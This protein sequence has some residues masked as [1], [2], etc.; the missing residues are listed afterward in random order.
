[1]FEEKL[2]N[3]LIMRNVRT[4][5]D[6]LKYV[7]LNRKYIN[8]FE[9]STCNILLRN[10]KTMTKEDF[11]LI[12]D[13]FSGD[14]L[15]TIC[16][17]P[18]EACFEGIVIQVAMLEMVLSHP[19]HRKLGLI[20]RLIQHFLSEVDKRG[21][22]ISVITGI[23]F[24]YRQYGYSYA[25]DLGTNE[26]LPACKL[27]AFSGS[28]SASYRLRKADQNDITQLASCYMA[29][30]QNKQVFIMRSC[31]HWSY[32]INEAKFD[33]RVVEDILT[34]SVTGYFLLKEADDKKTMTIFE[35]ELPNRAAMKEALSLLLSASTKEL[36][37][38]CYK[39]DMLTR[40]VKDLG[41]HTTRNTQWLLKTHDHVK[42]LNTIKPV[43]E[44]RLNNAGYSGLTTDVT[45]NL[46]KYA[47]KL[48]IKKG[49]IESI[50]NIGFV[51]S[52]MGSDGGDLCIPNDAFIR[53]LFGYRSID[54]L[55]DAWPDI[56]VKSESAPILQVL[57]P[58]LAVY[59]F[60]PYHYQG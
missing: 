24:Y 26:V 52:S 12:E 38:G 20:K 14:F 32:L 6:I 19:E 34:S 8:A 48:C 27:P 36:I 40:F 3:G 54:V 44:K 42:F 58:Q 35:A 31:D 25:I 50:S 28:E 45:I 49:M 18:W 57:F 22:D 10:H 30:T 17:I 7:D 59:F 15:A 13:T 39:D 16:L 56:V 23:P 51:D 4:E 33:I 53:L 41:S 5:E 43:L 55:W 47:I 46:F 60:T 9:G 37:I 2:E 21:Y 1:M 29:N 11:F